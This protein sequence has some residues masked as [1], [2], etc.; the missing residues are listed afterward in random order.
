MPKIFIQIASYRDRELIPTIKNCI[1]NAKYPKDLV[2]ALAWQHDATETLG[3]YAT[4]ARF[5][6]ID[7]PYQESQGVC[8]VRHKLNLLYSDE[9]YCLQLDSHHR[10]AKNWDTQAI[11]MLKDL[12]AAGYAKPLLTAYI[13]SYEPTNDPAGRVT[14]P[15]MICFDR[16]LP[17]GPRKM[18]ERIERRS[19][20]RF[21]SNS[22][23]E[24]L[25]NAVIALFKYFASCW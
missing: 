25:L 16:Y 10:F 20:C 8:W 19:A 21:P 9:E 14:D 18:N 22:T 7:I 4:D 15:W 23:R 17:E 24:S 13:P 11:G 2:F 5:K 12:Q 3:E 6:I 1:E